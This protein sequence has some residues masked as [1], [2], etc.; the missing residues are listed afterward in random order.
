MENQY[1]RRL[2][3]GIDTIQNGDGYFEDGKFEAIMSL[4]EL[5]DE[6]IFFRPIANP[7][8]R[9]KELEAE[10]ST[11]LKMLQAL[12]DNFPEVNKAFELLN[13]GD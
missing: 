9:I 5:V 12:K 10:N 3:T 13:K 11:L 4:G 1:Y 6:N 2:E 7:D 8:D